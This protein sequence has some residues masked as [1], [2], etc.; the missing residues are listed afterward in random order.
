MWYVLQSSIMFAV[1][2]SNQTWHWTPNGYLAA[3]IGISAAFVATG[4]LMRLKDVL[5][6]PAHRSDLPE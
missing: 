6:G 4:L 5:A 1:I 2:A 3:I